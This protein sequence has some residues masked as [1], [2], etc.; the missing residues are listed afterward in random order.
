MNW[1]DAP[2]WIA[3]AAAVVATFVAL[4]ARSDGKRSAAAAVR[5]AD[6]AAESLRLQQEAAQ[7]KVVLRI[8]R[9]SNGARLLT[10]AGTASANGLMLHPDDEFHV[11]WEESLGDLASGDVRPFYITAAAAPPSRLR[12][13]WDG[14]PSYV[15]VAMP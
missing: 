6:I 4:K 7:P 8:D 12:F 2:T 13:I 11:A 10:N 9:S 15:T 1:G 3:S 5:S 14:Q